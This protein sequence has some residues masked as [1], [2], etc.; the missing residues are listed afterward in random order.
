[1]GTFFGFS[2]STVFDGLQR[3]DYLRLVCLSL[4]SSTNWNILLYIDYVLYTRWTNIVDNAYGAKRLNQNTKTNFFYIFGGILFV[5][6]LVAVVVGYALSLINFEFGLALLITILVALVKSRKNPVSITRE[7]LLYMKDKSQNWLRQTHQKLENMLCY[8]V[9]CNRILMVELI[10]DCVIF[11]GLW[12]VR[13]QPNLFMS[14]AVLS[15]LAIDTITSAPG[16]FSAFEQTIYVR[17][18]GRIRLT[19]KTLIYR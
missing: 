18:L 9:V 15:S 7:F 10:L 12:V 5:I 11:L 8:L 17:S 1:M 6:G 19:L 3:A 2:C 13:I 14:L 4:F 16:A